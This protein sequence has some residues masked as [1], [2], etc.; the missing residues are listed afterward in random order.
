[1]DAEHPAALACSFLFV[2]GR[3]TD[4][5]DKALASGADIVVIDLEDAVPHGEKGAARA[6]VGGWLAQAPRID[7]VAVRLNSP[8]TDAGREDLAWLATLARRPATLVVPKAESAHD[9]AQVR[10]VAPGVA[11]VPL[12]ES[13]AGHAALNEIACAPGV[14]RLAF[15][16]LDFMADTGITA[17]DDENE[18]APMRFAIAMATTLARIAQ[19]IDG[20]TTDLDDEDR[21][22]RDAKR[23]AAFGFG[24]KLCIHPRQV[25][26]VH[27]A[28][29]PG[30]ELVAWAR[31]VLEGD[32]AAGGR[33]FRLDG[34]MVDAPVVLQARRVLA[35][36]DKYAEKA[37]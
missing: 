3:R 24:G 35:R 8:T 12:V 13:A 22:V 36:C 10:A 1:M 34:R 33:A 28:L 4:R 21:L 17:G 15:G 32:R 9:L 23:A 37:A 7:A 18:L 2:P 19:A 11:L 5:F 16:H 26:G 31:R 29:A 6:A 30:T 27:A 14:V 20:V 25:A